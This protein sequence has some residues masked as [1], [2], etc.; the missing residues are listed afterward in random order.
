M[1]RIL[2]ILLAVVML[3][4]CSLPGSAQTPASTPSPALLI[5]TWTPPPALPTNTPSATALI[6]PTWTPLLAFPTNTPS[7]S[8]LP[9]ATSTVTSPAFCNDPQVTN[10]LASLETAIITQNGALLSSLVSPVH[11]MDVRAFRNGNVINYDQQHA[12]FV[13]QTTYQALWGNHPASGLQVQGSFHQ[14]ILPELLKVFGQA[15]T[16]HC[17]QLQTGSATYTPQWPY[18]GQNYY[19]AYYAGTQGNSNL[20]WYTWAIG[21]EFVNGTPYVYALVPFYWEP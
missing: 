8:A 18:P 13:F 1:T 20:D 14:I 19:S 4:S 15:Y 12:Q 7:I 2:P 21:I 3:V 16:L 9:S 5:P 6:V 11:G 17:N 10:L